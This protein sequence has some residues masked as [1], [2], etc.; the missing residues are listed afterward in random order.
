MP[1]AMRRV[2]VLRAHSIVDAFRR[3]VFTAR[4][5]CF[6]IDDARIRPPTVQ[7]V[8]RRAPHVGRGDRPRDW[9]IGVLREAHIIQCRVDIVLMQSRIARIRQYLI[10]AAAEHDVAAQK[11]P[12]RLPLV[13]W[14]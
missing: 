5:G 6:K 9:A 3:K 11:K 4:N 7:F 10:D 8:E 14:R 13:N 12:H 2:G 1:A